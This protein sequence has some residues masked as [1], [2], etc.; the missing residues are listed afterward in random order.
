MLNDLYFNQRKYDDEKRL[1]KL[2]NQYSRLYHK[3][4]YKINEANDYVDP[5]E[6]EKSRGRIRKIYKKDID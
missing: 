2:K 4:A 1:M 6:L 3:L 5:I